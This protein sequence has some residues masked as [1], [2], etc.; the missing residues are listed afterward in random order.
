[1]RAFAFGLAFLTRLPGPAGMPGGAELGASVRAYGVAG[2]VVG[3][4]Q[5]GAL[6]LGS[7]AVHPLVGAVAAVAAGAWFTRGF[8]LDGLADC[9]DGLLA[10]GDRE[11]RLAVMKDPHVGALAAVAVALWLMLKVA[12]V[13]ATVERSTAL[14]A[15]PLAAVLA[16][17][18]LPLELAAGPSATPAGLHATLS[19]VVR[20]ADVAWGVGLALPVLWLAPVAGSAGLVLALG[21]TWAWRRTWR[22]IL[23]GFNGDVLG[24]SV[25]LREACVLGALASPLLS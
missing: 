22:R 23:G 3:G 9:A 10:N 24:A 5:L 8:H 6:T 1:V 12:L 7:W 25:E 17:A 16:R 14:V 2:W 13:A 4:V 21:L 19:A 11:R 20:P 18:P 15:L